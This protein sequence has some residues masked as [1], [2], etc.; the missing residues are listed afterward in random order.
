M[1]F[2]L[3][4]TNIK[5]VFLNAYIEEKIYV[6]QPPSFED[7]K[8]PNYVYMLKKALYGLKQT[9]RQW[10]ERLSNLPLEKKLREEKLIK[11]TFH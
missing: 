11:N 5:S 2:K 6:S 7:H 3:Y 10:F 8:N 9:K 4:Q 1:D